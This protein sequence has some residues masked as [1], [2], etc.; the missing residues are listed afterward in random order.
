MGERLRPAW[1]PTETKDAEPVMRGRAHFGEGLAGRPVRSFGR[2]MAWPD[3]CDRFVEDHGL[4]IQAHNHST[5]QSQCPPAHNRGDP[6][7]LLT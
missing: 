4:T 6:A 7:P 3:R 2:R 1:P 5:H